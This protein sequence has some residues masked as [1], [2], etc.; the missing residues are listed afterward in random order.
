MDSLM[1]TEKLKMPLLNRAGALPESSSSECF[2][3]GTQENRIGVPVEI[4]ILIHDHH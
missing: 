1:R 2:V 4:L 3:G